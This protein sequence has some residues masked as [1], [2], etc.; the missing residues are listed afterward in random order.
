MREP[1]VLRAV[2]HLGPT[3]VAA[4]VLIGY[5]FVRNTPYGLALG[6]NIVIAAIAA[7]GLTLTIGGAGQLALGQAGFMAIGGYGGAYL[8]KDRGVTFAAA[9]ALS[10]VLAAVVGALVGYIALRLRGNYL[11]MATL[12]VGSGIYGLLQNNQTLGGAN[13]Y[14]PIP[15]PTLLGHRLVEPREQ[16]LLAAVTLVVVLL[17]AR[18]LLAAR[19]GRE[20]AA[21]RDDEV[22]ARAIGINI[23]ARKVQVFALTSAIGALAGAVNGPL[24]TAI[25]P[26][27]YAPSV[28]LALFVMVVLGG[29]GNV[30]GAALGAALVTWLISVVPGNGSWALTVLGVVVIVFMAVLPDGLVGV[31][32]IARAAVR[33]TRRGSHGAP[34]AGTAAP[35][36]SVAP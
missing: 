1:L 8:M 33:R 24:Q 4:V 25:D 10:V 20:L 13:G 9:V 6:V 26:S 35:G 18:T 2:K 29:L 11:A 5:A 36:A 19:A 12:A 32:R 7:V 14:A 27:L 30:Y 15:F 3:A 34:R 16:Y 17:G 28:S 22:A 21:L 23:T 31:P